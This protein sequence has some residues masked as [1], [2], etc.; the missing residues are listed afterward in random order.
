MK[1]QT[2]NDLNI[3][4]RKV[5]SLIK[6][7]KVE[8]HLIGIYKDIIDCER[9]RKWKA[10]EDDGENQ[11]GF[12]SMSDEELQDELRTYCTDLFVKNFGNDSLQDLMRYMMNVWIPEV[13]IPSIAN[14]YTFF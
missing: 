5:V 6:S 10:Q 4:Y 9:H 12:G 2:K 11:T 13:R 7:G 1:I 14:R 3:D 8:M